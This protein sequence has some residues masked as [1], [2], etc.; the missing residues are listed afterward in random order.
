MFM[1]TTYASKDGTDL[2][3]SPSNIMGKGGPKT[4]L[5]ATNNLDEENYA[6]PTTTD[7][8]NNKATRRDMERQRRKE[9]A[10]LYASLRSQIPYEYTKVRNQREPLHFL[11]SNRILYMLA[12]LYWS[13]TSQ[14]ST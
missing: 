11:R 12:S 10:S 1:S 13:F 9:M 5:L 3:S 14:Q 2:F 8:G 4:K 6:K 7:D